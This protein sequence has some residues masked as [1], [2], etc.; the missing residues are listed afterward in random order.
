MFPE[1][2]FTSDDQLY[3]GK[4]GPVRELNSFWVNLLLLCSEFQMQVFHSFIVTNCFI[5]NRVAVNPLNTGREAGVHPIW[6]ANGT[7]CESSTHPF[8]K[9]FFRLKLRSSHVPNIKE[10]RRRLGASVS[11]NCVGFFFFL[12]EHLCKWTG[13]DHETICDFFFICLMTY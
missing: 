1:L 2:C 6:D 4:V 5:L 13:V 12:S 10:L 8:F 7:G 11:Q 3:M 9:N